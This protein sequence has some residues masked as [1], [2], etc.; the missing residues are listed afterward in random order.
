MSCAATIESTAEA[1]LSAIQNV[2]RESQ[3]E[4]E[5][6]KTQRSGRSLVQTPE[7]H[8]L[9]LHDGNV[10]RSI[11]TTTYEYDTHFIEIVRPVVE[12]RSKP[13]RERM[14]SP[15]E[16]KEFE[17][18]N[19]PSWERQDSLTLHPYMNKT[20][21]EMYKKR[22]LEELTYVLERYKAEKPWP[23]EFLRELVAVAFRYSLQS[24]YITVRAKTADGKPGPRIG[25]VRTISVPYK[26]IDSSN[27]SGDPRKMALA[28]QQLEA[29]QSLFR[30]GIRLPPESLPNPEL[31]REI[32]DGGPFVLK[33]AATDSPMVR[34]TPEQAFIPAP[35]EVVLNRLYDRD[36]NPS[37]A[38]KYLV[39][40][41]N[42]ALTPDRDLA[43]ELRGVAAAALY[44][45]LARVIKVEAGARGPTTK[46]GTYASHRSTSDRFYRSLGF[47]LKEQIAPTAGSPTP[48]T[49]NVLMGDGKVLDLALVKRFKLE[50]SE[51]VLS[52]TFNRFNRFEM[53]TQTQKLQMPDTW[54]GNHP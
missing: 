1:R 54:V 35:F 34:M 9:L 40:P 38:L 17:Y 28:Q 3:Q 32:F 50:G 14:L 8:K 47:G 46:V 10:D 4:F 44:F 45:H 30:G 33:P 39:E 23:N 41:G 2:V 18:L 48:E 16:V 21:V 36:R 51:S 20:A 31:W 42:F 29:D 49:W 26:D 25:S 24:T 12:T 53:R 6:T 43:P 7:G 11:R 13:D 15:E 5:I 22:I 27:S 19:G 37:D 52:A